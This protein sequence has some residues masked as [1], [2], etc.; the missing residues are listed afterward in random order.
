MILSQIHVAFLFPAFIFILARFGIASME[1][2]LIMELINIAK[3]GGSIF[4]AFRFSEDVGH[5]LG[6]KGVLASLSGFYPGFFVTYLVS[7]LVIKLVFNTKKRPTSISRYAGFC[8]G[9]LEGCIFFY[10]LLSM[11]LMIPGNPLNSSAPKFSEKLTELTSEIV[12]PLLPASSTG[13]IEFIK[14]ASEMRNGVDPKKVDRDLLRQSLEPISQ[15]PELQNI[16]SDQNLMG[17]A[18]KKDIKG[19]ISHPKVKQLLE[20][21]EF[22]KKL[23]SINWVQL[24]K[25]LKPN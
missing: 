19:L 4:V 5:F 9:I 16:T 20:S 17:M 10:I 23:K 14:L 12:S 25:A 3:L 7:G 15:L 11:S 21:P 8:F 13:T 18:Q 1:K 6:L 2:G 24:R 22:Q